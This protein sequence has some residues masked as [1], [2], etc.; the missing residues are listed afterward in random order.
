[1]ASINLNI[2]NTLSV[3][4][5]NY[6]IKSYKVAWCIIKETETKIKNNQ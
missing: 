3:N 4:G 6:P 2:N 1:M 5:L